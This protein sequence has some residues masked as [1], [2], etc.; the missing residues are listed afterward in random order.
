MAAAIPPAMLPRVASLL[1][2]LGSD[3]DHEALGAM[4]A[5][6]RTLGGVGLDLHSLA[7]AVEHPAPEPQARCARKPRVGDIEL[8]FARRRKVVEALRRGL[9]GSRMTE[10]ERTFA[11]SIVEQLQ[12]RRWQITERQAETLGRLLGKIGEG[13]AWA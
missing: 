9:G 4:R 8:D 2:L 1:R 7:E 12:S 13:R 10:W 11:S 6:R 5:L 3:H